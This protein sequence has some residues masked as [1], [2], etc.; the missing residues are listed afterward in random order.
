MKRIIRIPIHAAT[1]EEIN[2]FHQRLLGIAAEHNQ[3]FFLEQN[4]KAQRQIAEARESLLDS[5]IAENPVL[6][7]NQFLLTAL[8]K[9]GILTHRQMVDAIGS[10]LLHTY[11]PGNRDIIKSALASVGLLDSPPGGQNDKRPG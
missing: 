11:L 10:G 7:Q 6:Q 2:G 5:L 3:Q 9:R 8:Q 4:A 1:E